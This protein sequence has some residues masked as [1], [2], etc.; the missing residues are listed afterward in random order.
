MGMQYTK[1]PEDAYNEIQMNAAMV[2]TS[3]VPSTGVANGQIGVTSGGVNITVQPNFIDLGEDMDN[4]P[5]NTMELMRIDGETITASFTMVTVNTATAK[6]AM[7]A[8]DIDGTDTSKIVARD[9]LKSTDFTGDLWIIG[10]YSS[11]NTGAGTAGFCAVHL[12]NVL[13]TGGFN[14]QTQ[15][16]G[17]G[18]FSNTFTAYR[19]LEDPDTVPYEVYIKEGT[20]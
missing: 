1:V 16:K 4:V 17:K 3:F 5:K 13:S 6:L 8:A 19:S 2:C 14:W 11:A 18:Q 12:K 15:D 20:T 9:Q 10:D 7:A